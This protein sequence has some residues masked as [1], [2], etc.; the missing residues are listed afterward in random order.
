MLGAN[1]EDQWMQTMNLAV[2]NWIVELR[3]SNHSFGVPL[4]LFSYALSASGL[5]KVQMYCPVIA[6][7]MEELFAYISGVMWTLWSLRHLWQNA[8]M[9][10]RRST[11]HHVS[12]CKSHLCSNL[13]YCLFQSASPTT[14]PHM[15]L[16]LR[17]ALRVHLIRQ[18]H[19]VLKHQSLKALH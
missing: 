4:P 7:G 19:L 15:N 16:V 1:L 3:S 18:S 13:M 11:S 14:T 12:C 2:T 5:W 10:P 6:M 17:R 8:D 9:A